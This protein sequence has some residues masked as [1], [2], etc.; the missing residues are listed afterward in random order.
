MY[1]L[2]Q[3]NI[4]SMGSAQSR[5]DHVRQDPPDNLF[6]IS[7]SNLI[8]SILFESLENEMA[9]IMSLAIVL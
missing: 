5:L 1:L 3:Y 7:F 9:Q 4:I 2:S 6:P 8:Y